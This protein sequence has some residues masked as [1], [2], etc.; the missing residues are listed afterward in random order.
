MSID[1][2]S[3]DEGRSARISYAT[4]GTI[5]Q[6]LT[7]MEGL[8][9]GLRSDI[10]YVR[11][12]QMS[13]STEHERRFNDQELRIRALEAKRVVETSAMWK[14]ATAFFGAGTIV[15]AIIALVSK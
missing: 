15:V 3:D 2:G 8:I 6:A 14:L 1:V 11:E 10:Q 12:A 5:Q 9:A 7:R 13:K 4:I